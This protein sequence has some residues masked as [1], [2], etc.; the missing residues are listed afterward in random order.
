MKFQVHIIE[1]ES[2][3]GQRVDE[4]KIFDSKDYGG[5]ADKALAAA[6]AFVKQYN[7]KNT[8]RTTPAWYM[9]ATE[10]TMVE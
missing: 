5:D 2:G 3:W 9:K 1:S 10:P 7:S 6:K 4:T 8:S